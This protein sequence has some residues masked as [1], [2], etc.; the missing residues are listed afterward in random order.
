VL[1]LVLH[2]LPVDLARGAQRY[3]RAM[4]RALDGDGARHR[5]LTLFRSDVTV[6][7]A[8][9]KLDLARSPSA[10]YDLRVTLALHAALRDLRPRIVVAHGS[11]PL[12]Y[13]AAWPSRDAAVVYY[14]IGIATETLHRPLRRALHAGL[15]RRADWVAGVSQA[16]LDEAA[17]TFWVPRRRLVLIP[18]GR[19]VQCYRPGSTSDRA[20]APVLAFVGHLTPSKRPGLFVDVVARLRAAGV[21]VTAVM[22]GD[23]PLAPAL[24]GPAAAAG[25]SMLGRRDD[26]PEILR[27]A[28]LLLFTSI[29]EGEGM[30]GVFIEAGLSGVPIVATEVP[31]SREVI[32]EGET[33][34]VVPHNHGELLIDR[35]RQLLTDADLRARMGRAARAHCAAHFSME[36]STALWASLV[37]RVVRTDARLERDVRA[38]RSAGL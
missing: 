36:K 3:A 25:V 12:K 24:A 19:D 11:E 15:L 7:D 32:R 2:V 4:R 5:T 26:V 22:V 23:G 10:R 1:P 37:A 8:D 6:L 13:L 20:G 17:D 28:D 35:T 34:F 9:V 27:S 31:G 14:K 33:G 29:P 30:P 16:C 18:N 38:R 21:D